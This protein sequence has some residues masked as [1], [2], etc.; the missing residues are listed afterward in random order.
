MSETKQSATTSA[1]VPWE[2]VPEHALDKVEW[3]DGRHDNGQTRQ[4]ADDL[5]LPNSLLE[6]PELHPRRPRGS[7]AM[8][9]AHG[10][11]CRLRGLRPGAWLISPL[12]GWKWAVLPGRTVSWVPAETDLSAAL[13]IDAR[14]D[15]N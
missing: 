7:T 4:L 5:P 13:R 2:E 15:V 11:K 9:D 3:I 14:N 6:L 8:L 10:A 1:G 12:T